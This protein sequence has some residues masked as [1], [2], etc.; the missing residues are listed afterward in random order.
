MA[1][2]QEDR[3]AAIRAVTSTTETLNGDWHALFTAVGATSGSTFNERLLAWVNDQLAT[4]Y[5]NLNGALYAYA[6][7]Q[8]FDRW[9]AVGNGVDLSDTSP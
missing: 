9:N 6:A 5:S 3:Q 8:S 7:N 2:N 4:S 1:T